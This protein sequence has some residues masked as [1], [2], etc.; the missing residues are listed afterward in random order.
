MKTIL[1]IFI[2]SFVASAFSMVAAAQQLNYTAIFQ[3]LQDAQTSIS[4]DIATTQVTIQEQ[5]DVLAGIDAQIAALISTTGGSDASLDKQRQD[6]LDIINALQATLAQYQS[7]LADIQ[8]KVVEYT[9]LRNQYDKAWIMQNNPAITYNPASPVST[10][11]SQTGRIT[12]VPNPN[13]PST[14]DVFFQSTGS[15][16]GDEKV[17][18]DW[19]LQYGLVDY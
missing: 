11:N 12:N 18:H 4:Q 13:I 2:L 7:A 14:L 15:T 10:P 1:K 5:Q 3:E 19:L 8:T 16:V 17:V 9:N 6:Q